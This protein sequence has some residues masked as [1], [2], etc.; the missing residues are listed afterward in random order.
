[1]K[2]IPVLL[3]LLVSSVSFAQK[4]QR[5]MINF[6][7]NK[8]DIT[9]PAAARLDSFMASLPA[10]RTGISIELYG[11][12]DS[13]G[14][15]DYN[16]ALSE[17]RATAVKKYLSDKGLESSVIAKE[18]GLG[19]RQP[20]N[21]N[22]SELD[23][24]LNRRVEMLVTYPEEKPVEKLVEKPI[25]KP[26]EKTIT[27]T[28]KD[29]ATKV[30]SRINL[31]NLNFVGGNH[32]LLPQSMPVLQELLEVMKNNP[33]LVIAI[34]G[35]VCCVPDKNDGVDFATGIANLSEARARTVYDYLVRNGIDSRRLSYK[36]FGH[37]FPVYP[38]PERSDIEMV[39]NRRVEIR[40]VNK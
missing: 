12:C 1:M 39:T 3:L 13:I 30:G 18:Q 17:K 33:Q 31:Q 11:H 14:S 32:I 8:Y 26:V 38:Y 27:E 28:I 25:E 37:Q 23:R 10:T 36:G 15:N 5:L 20:L 40:I 21:D 7:F 34:E 16:D 19:K 24:Y 2:L 22:S 29:T 35:H 4:Q 9:A 6:D